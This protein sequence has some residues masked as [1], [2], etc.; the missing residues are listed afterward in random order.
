MSIQLTKENIVVQPVKVLQDALAS[1]QVSSRELTQAFIDHSEKVDTKIGAILTPMY[2]KALIAA[3]AAD[4]RIKNG[5]KTP[6][7]GIPVGIKD[8]ISTKGTQTTAGSKILEGYVPP[9]NATVIDKLERDGAVL[10]SKLNLDEFA[11]GSSCEN[12]GYK[13][14]FNPWDLTRTP[15]GSS[16]GSA[17]AVAAG[18]CPFSLG[19]DTGG[20]IRQPA[21]FCNLVGVKPTYGRVSRYGVIAY[22]SSLDQ[23]GTFARD[24]HGAASLLQVISG[25]DPH[26]STSS[27]R[28][29]PDYTASIGKDVK[30]L[31]IGVPKEYFLD[32]LNA[33]IRHLVQSGIDL[34][35]KKGAQ[36][37]EI[38]L[39]HTDY[40]VSTYYLC[41]TAE[42]S[43]NLARYDG[44]HYGCR[45][46]NV[47]NLHDMYFRSRSE[48]FGEEVKRRILL[49]TFVLSAGYY[50]AYYIKALQV[51]RLIQQDFLNAFNNVDCIIT[52][53]SP[54]PPFKIGE[55]TDD[56]LHMYLADI[57]TVTASLA[58]LPGM[59]IPCGF[60]K[61]GKLPVG[62]QIICPPWQEEHLF[63]IGAAYEQETSWTKETAAIVG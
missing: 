5:E 37:V 29:V 45:A 51:R 44:A 4:V 12:S 32:G 17:A 15:G 23:V 42:A 8:V 59:S 7:L 16:G 56:P 14:T 20:S 22:A 10:I 62:M 49:G 57:F 50:D 11:M 36:I 3:D 27:A 9:Y 26:D 63:K 43:S 38:S 1:K 25:E 31:R 18:E 52:P 58:G 54:I 30:G 55:L 46:D 13:K 39:P 61:E 21:S 24:I 28:T 6:V 60:T 40:A 35:V 34:L 19:T 48:A 2:D 47:A 33:E 53:T 41:A